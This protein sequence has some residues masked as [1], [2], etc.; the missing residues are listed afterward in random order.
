MSKTSQYPDPTILIRP[1]EETDEAAV[2]DL[3]QEVFPDAPAWNDPLND[4]RRKLTVQPELFFIAM[5]DR[6]LVGTAMAG[7]DGHRGWVY[8]VVVSPNHRRQGIGSALMG[9]TEEALREKG[10]PKLN[11]QVRASNHEVVAFYRQLG[12][13]IEERV[14]MAKRLG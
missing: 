9:H 14:S 11:L 2:V 5:K 6:Q 1:Y 13:E 10:C 8:Y 7:Y 3:W 4:I 12:Y